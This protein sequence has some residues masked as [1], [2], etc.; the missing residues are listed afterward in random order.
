MHLALATNS[1]EAIASTTTFSDVYDAVQKLRE[2]GYPKRVH[3]Y[4]V[5]GKKAERTGIRY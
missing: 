3:I 4:R 1:K 2:M 5:D